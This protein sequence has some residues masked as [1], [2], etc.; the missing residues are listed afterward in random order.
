MAG[1]AATRPAAKALGA[2]D[3][4]RL[5][6]PYLNSAIR[7]SQAMAWFHGKVILGTGRSPLGVLGSFT[8]R[9]GA[10]GGTQRSDTGGRDI[11]GAQIVTFDPETETWTKIFDSPV[12]PGL[13]GTPRARDRSV[14]AALVCQ[15]MADTKPTLYLGVGSLERNVTFLR[16]ED[17]ETITTCGG[18]G[19]NVE[20]DVPSVRAMACLNG[21]LFSTPTGR[22]YGR[23]IY[24]DNL[25][26]HPIVFA[27]SDPVSGNWVPVSE[28]GFGDPENVAIN[29]LVVFNDHLYAATLNPRRGFQLWKTDGQG[30]PPYRW[31]K[32]IDR[33]AWLGPTSSIPAAVNIFNGAL[34][35]TATVQRQGRKTI[36]NYGPFPAEMI[37]VY[38]NDDW[39]LVS[40]TAR[41]SPSGIKRP[42][43]GMTGGFGDR[44]THA[45]WRTAVFN[46]ELIV[47]TAGWRWLPT[48]LRDRHELSDAQYRRLCEESD[49]YVPGEFKLYRSRD[50]VTWESITQHG[51]PGSSPNNCGVREILSTPH[52]LFVAPVAMSGS[53]GGG[54]LELWWGRNK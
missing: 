22:N 24:D 37:R 15:T 1:R 20:G 23:G 6:I 14:R 13:D 10:M 41:F 48:Y 31:T 51:F 50:G 7:I 2:E 3:F 9:E 17:G 27:A 43:S 45:F 53:S 47:G 36:D 11:D 33:G 16:S 46:D 12:L 19:F 5:E 34:Y 54:G 39:D 49:D 8:G 38:A 30:Q 21:Q 52:G 28:P 25:T 40:G 4:Q 32:V 29:E 44:Y 26:D 42:I 18:S 35:I